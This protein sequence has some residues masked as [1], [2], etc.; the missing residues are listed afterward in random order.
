MTIALLLGPVIAAVILT[1]Y[2]H[3][4]LPGTL[5]TALIGSGTLA[6]V[7]IAWVTS[8]GGGAEPTSVKLGV[9]AD[10]L[11]RS[12][13]DQWDPELAARQRHDISNLSV[14]WDPASPHL[15]T[16]WADMVAMA[17]G[18]GWSATPASD[19]WAA[20]PGV[21]A[22]DGTK[23]TDVYAK[24]P[25]GRLVVLGE[26][27]SGKSMLMARLLLDLLLVRAEGG[28]VPVMVTL[29]SWPLEGQSAQSL[30]QFIEE[31]L[32]RDDPLLGAPVLVGG[33]ETS[34]I[35][36][37]LDER[38]VVPILDG[39]DEIPAAFRAEAVDRINDLLMRP[40]PLVVSSRKAEYERATDFGEDLVLGS[41][42]IE[43]RPLEADAIQRYLADTGHN[44]P[45]RAKAAQ[46]RWEPVLRDLSESA[47][48]AEA[49]RT[50]LFVTLARAIYNPRRR[51]R[52]SE[53]ADPAELCD[54]A[55]FDTAEPIK[56][57]LFDA[58]I[59]AVYR[60]VRNDE[61]PD[62]P[63][64]YGPDEAGEWLTYLADFLER[65]KD[66]EQAARRQQPVLDGSGNGS[67]DLVQVSA[68]PAGLR[69]DQSEPDLEQTQDLEWWALRD[70]T[71]RALAPAIVGSVCGIIVGIA[72]ALGTHVGVGIGVG[73]G[74]GMILALAIG[75]GAMWRGKF[76]RDTL[77]SK[78]LRP[79]SGMC[80]A[81]LGAA[82]GGVAAG[83]AHKVGFGHET[84][85]F[86][87]LPEALGIGI[88]GGASTRFSGGLAGGLVGGFFGGV[89]EGVGLGIPAGIVN[90]LGVG[91]AAGLAVY[92]VG[93]RAPAHST[94]TWIWNIGV[95]GGIVIGLVVGLITW[96]QE[97]LRD[98]IGLGVILGAL[99]AWPFG[100]RDTPEE[101]RAVPS[102]RNA[103]IRDAR[104][105]R[106]TSLSSGLASAVAGFFGGGLAS[107]FEIGAKATVST[108]VA[109]GLGIGL[110]SGLVIG[111]TFGFYH[112]ASPTYLISSWWLAMRRKLP[113]G[114]MKFLEDAHQKSV[115]RQNGA[116][117]QFR[118]EKLRVHLTRADRNPDAHSGVGGRS[119]VRDLPGEAEF[120]RA[121]WLR[122]GA[123]AP[124]A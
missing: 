68:R 45:E 21:L 15:C 85:L 76:S 51:E 111:I 64:L 75:R 103:L 13:H 84:S 120:A 10:E 73:F 57:Y 72:A 22:G 50:P 88:G 114:L 105:F 44:L 60:P 79:G 113:W 123:R 54:R 94:P 59:P 82:I 11:A 106:L 115:L 89:L 31:K 12:M 25:T 63:P 108:V 26:A 32:I 71:P 28:P 86:S 69:S 4:S 107:I 62:G 46:A 41:V 30:P 53:L 81:L 93:R 122:R 91:L 80:G 48:L 19:T 124:S 110:A 77:R 39:L 87:G 65:Q 74:T 109:D 24:V 101:L 56:D 83:L 104:A 112:A 29:G 27:G 116:V 38:M 2:S 97:G 100:L 78:D 47:P 42:A 14:S 99:A 61:H 34:R 92:Y 95:P 49:F 67:G 3:L 58:F 121:R 16:D 18:A 118:H 33:R 98:G 7:Y 8:R 6:G 90:G 37:L 117:Y 70:A 66:K 96:R 23:L 119:R 40:G 17:E 9:I 36:A 102:P 1:Q 52:S 35:R 20:G 43:L 5:I 55:R